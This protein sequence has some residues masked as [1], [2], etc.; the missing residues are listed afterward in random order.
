MNQKLLRAN[1]Y[2]IKLH[3][4]VC[5]HILFCGHTH[6]NPL[7]QWEREANIV[8]PLLWEMAGVRFGKINCHGLLAVLCN[9]IFFEII[10]EKSVAPAK[11]GV[12]FLGALWI[13]AFAGMTFPE[14]LVIK[15][16]STAIAVF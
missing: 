16:H 14:V 7:P 8:S 9:F 6:P 12:Q 10:Y 2:R 1:G 4:L 3:A 5:L 13:P 15:L 11:A